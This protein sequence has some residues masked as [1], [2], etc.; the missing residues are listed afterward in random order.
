[1]KSTTAAC[2]LA[3]CSSSTPSAQDPP[4]LPQVIYAGATTDEAL[5]RM[6]A[7]AAEDVSTQHLLIDSP[8][9]GASLP[10][11]ESITLSFQQAAATL[12]IPASNR[13]RNARGRAETR[14]PLTRFMAWLS[15]LGVAHAHGAPFNGV[16]YYLVLSDAAHQQKLRVFSDR[17]SYTI[18]TP[19]GTALQAAKQPLTLTITKAVFEENEVTENGGPFLAGSVDFRVE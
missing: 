3:A 2:F 7:L 5:T 1:M 18:E 16:G 9:P 8:A 19:L 11:S 6:L 12:R 17:R 4:E 13:Q 14:S 10:A 15:P